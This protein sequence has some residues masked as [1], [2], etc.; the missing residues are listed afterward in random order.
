M[1]S[2]KIANTASTTFSCFLRLVAA[3]AVNSE[4]LLLLK[5]AYSS[6]KLLIK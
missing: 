3:A 1:N 2:L 6:S 4:L 5:H